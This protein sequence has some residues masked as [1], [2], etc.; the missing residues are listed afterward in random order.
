MMFSLVRELAAEGIPVRLTCRVLGLSTQAFYKW[1]KQPVCDRDLV[2]AY[3]TN[4][5][6]DAA[7]TTPSSGTGSSPMSSSGPATALVSGGCGGCAV[8]SDC[9]RPPHEKAA[10]VQANGPARRCMT[11]SCNVTSLPIPGTP[12][13]LP[14]SPSTHW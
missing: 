1:C 7:A 13:G 2:D 10:T 4:E 9:G 12:S 11:I 14:I 5:L 6:V 8:S 3:L